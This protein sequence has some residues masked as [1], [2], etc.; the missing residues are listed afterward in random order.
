MITVVWE[1]R[2]ANCEFLTLPGLSGAPLEQSS[3]KW[4][5]RKKLG[6]MYNLVHFSQLVLSPRK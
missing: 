2:M 1:G 4:M 3:S 6:E 5:E